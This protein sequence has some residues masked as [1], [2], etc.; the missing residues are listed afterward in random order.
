MIERFER[1]AAG[2]AVGHYRDLYLTGWWTEVS[3]PSLQHIREHRLEFLRTREGPV[4]GIQLVLQIEAKRLS[5]EARALIEQINRGAPQRF[6]AEAFYVAGGS[7]ALA[8]VRFV[9]AG[10]QLVN[11]TE[12]PLE[13]FGSTSDAARWLATHSATPEH[14]LAAAIN[15]F[16]RQ[17]AER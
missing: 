12:W 15:Q 13:V 4:I 5:K 1:H 8:A 10:V 3:V 16:A 14:E 17:C 9:I 2:S 6:R 7:I 11:K